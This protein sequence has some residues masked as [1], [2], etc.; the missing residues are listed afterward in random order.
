MDNMQWITCNGLKSTAGISAVPMGLLNDLICIELK[1]KR[2]EVVKTQL[3]WICNP[4]A[5]QFR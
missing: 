2:Y 1:I 3:R 4:A 5:S